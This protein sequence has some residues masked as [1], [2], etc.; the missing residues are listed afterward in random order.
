MLYEVI[1]A[2][3]NSIIHGIIK[4]LEKRDFQ[5][6]NHTQKLETYVTA[7]ANSL[8]L[9]KENVARLKSYNFV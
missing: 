5:S 7:V 4:A 6:D 9:P 1:T 2:S 8:N 3:R